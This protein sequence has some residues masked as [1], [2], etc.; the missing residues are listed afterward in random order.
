MIDASR[1]LDMAA[2][3]FDRRRWVK[4][5]VLMVVLTYIGGLYIEDLFRRVKG[6]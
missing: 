2:A 5:G 6:L 1:E 3:W 4:V